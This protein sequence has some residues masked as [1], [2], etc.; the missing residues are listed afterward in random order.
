MSIMF[1]QGKAGIESMIQQSLLG[2]AEGLNGEK[3]DVDLVEKE[4]KRREEE[5]RPLELQ[6]Q[7]NI[8]FVEG[9]QYMDI[10]AAG[11]ELVEIPEMYP[12]QEREVFN[13]IA[14]II[15]TREA[16]LSRMRTILKVRPGTGEQA[17]LRASKIGSQ[18]LHNIYNDEGIRD[19][20]NE[21]VSWM[22][23]F[24][25][26]LFKNT[27]NPDKGQIVANEMGLDEMGNEIGQSGIRE[28]DIDVALVPCQEIYPDSIY[29][30]DVEN[31]KSIIH[32]RAYHIDEI[33]EIWGVRVQPEKTVAMQM[34]RTMTSVG[35]L[36]YGSGEFKYSNKELENH[37]LVKEYYERPS[38]KYPEGR[39]I[40]VAGK[41]LLHSGPLEFPVEEDGNVGIPFVKVDCITR[42]GVFFGKT[43]VERC[44]PIQRRYNALRNRKAEHL[45]RVGIGQWLVERDAVDMDIFE[46]QAGAPGAVLEYQKGYNPPRPVD[47][48]S[49]PNDFAI[50]ANELMTEFSM[51][52]GVS[53]MS[54][55][56]Q[57]P[58]GV[59]SGV[60]LSIAVEQDDT[61]LASTAQ[62]LESFLVA[63]GKQWLRLYR[64]YVQGPRL[65]RRVNKNNVVEILDW[66]ASDLRS[67]DVVLDTFS[68]LAESP[69]QRR[70]M[71]FDLLNTPLFMD[72][73]TGQIDRDMR[74]KIFEMMEFG[75]WESADDM[76]DL[77]KAK[78]ER[79]NRL[80]KMGQVPQAA[81]YDQHV[82][83]INNHNKERLGTE[84]EELISQ[85]PMLNEVFQ[86]HVDQ[87]INFIM[88]TEMEQ[89]PMSEEEPAV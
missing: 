2:G 8:A 39:L 36:G 27:W 17:D 46:A 74:M 37:A 18:L 28:G 1:D 4:F 58:P 45:N 44:I 33:E 7:L 86:A 25:S 16:K 6:W 43:I 57:A 23:R 20:Q 31:C 49:L 30:Q 10:N 47:Q 76:D 87:H 3:A 77:H 69:A 73:D 22:E 70:Q 32:A 56:S 81:Q 24:G 34:Q 5:R 88:M 19:L 61:R 65:L 51:M 38:K 80:M 15:E 42:P 67:D 83:H 60:A 79:E 82:I 9:N 85:N 53:E 11:M 52:S 40:I 59:K 75:N 84:F 62:N 64:H 54:R 78:A 72:P 63:N 29:H 50:E 13:H 66:Q 21:A 35:G 48:P 41:Q 12:W 55:M 68:A 71:I 14:P 89:E 26:V